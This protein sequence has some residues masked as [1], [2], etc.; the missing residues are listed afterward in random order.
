MRELNVIYW[1]RGAAYYEL[2]QMSIASVERVHPKAGHRVYTDDPGLSGTVR[3]LPR[4]GRPAMLANLDAQVLALQT[5]PLYSRFL[6]LDADVLLAKPLDVDYHLTV[7]WRDKIIGPDGQSMPADAMPYN[8]GVMGGIVC[9]ETI[10]VFTWIRQRIEVMSRKLQNWYG[11]QAA[12][13]E[14]LGPASTG[15]HHK[16]IRASLD[17]PGIPFDV[18]MLPC[19]T[20]NYTP[21]AI[22][23]DISDKVAIHLKGDRKDMVYHYAERLGLTVRAAA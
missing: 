2:A 8:Y 23:E 18:H 10:E 16:L 11:N 19:D 15:L 9:P 1:V 7:T 22:D 21:Q 13:A 5:L 4:Q 3:R 14:L 20:H 6:F 17:D 12:M